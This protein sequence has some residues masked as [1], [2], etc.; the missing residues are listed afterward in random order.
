M[1]GRLL[2]DDENWGAVEWSEKRQALCIEDTEGRCLS[3]HAHVHG[4]DRDKDDAVA[5]AETMIR[6]GRMPT[7]EDAKQAR[8]ERLKR[9][10]PIA[11]PP[12][13]LRHWY[14]TVLHAGP[15]LDEAPVKSRRAKR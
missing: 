13:A 1:I 4:E 2:I 6:D 10:L 12:Q 11:D 5:L 8:Q 14:P 15:F 7:P 9:D 3:H